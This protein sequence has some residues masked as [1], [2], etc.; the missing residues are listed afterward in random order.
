MKWSANVR[1]VHKQ[2]VHVKFQ[3]VKD[4]FFFAI[5]VYGKN[6][7]AKTWDLW[8]I[9]MNIA[10]SITNECWINPILGDFKETIVAHERLE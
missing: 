5:Y 2:Y 7:V 4:Y 9:I 6:K 8:Y 10:Q 1:I 3:N